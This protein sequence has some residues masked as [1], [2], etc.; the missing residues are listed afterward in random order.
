MNFSDKSS[1]ETLIIYSLDISGGLFI[2]L[3]NSVKRSS[4]PAPARIE[5]A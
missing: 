1:M 3:M 4:P 2:L 5:A